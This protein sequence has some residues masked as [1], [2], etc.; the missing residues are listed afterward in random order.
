MDAEF[1]SI[2][3]F[4]LIPAIF[5]IVGVVLLIKGAKGLYR[6][7]FAYMTVNARCVSVQELPGEG[8]NQTLYRPIYEYEYEGERITASKIDYEYENYVQEG[9]I[10]PIVV[11]KKH[12][13]VIVD[14]KPSIVAPIIFLFMGFNFTIT[15]L[16][17]VIPTLFMLL[18]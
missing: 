12:P 8:G 10:F 9:S 7:L 18:L 4:T 17:M 15:I 3:M 1:V 6:S 5:V 14:G 13:D 16:S 2:L 11:E